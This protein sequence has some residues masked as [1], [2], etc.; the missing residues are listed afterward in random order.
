MPAGR[1]GKDRAELGGPKVPF[2]ATLHI[3]QSFK[4]WAPGRAQVSQ[5]YE[6]M[7]FFKSAIA[8]NGASPPAPP[9]HP[10]G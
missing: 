5:S 3:L 4:K 9:F 6:R 1:L 8:P 2:R 7:I 10:N